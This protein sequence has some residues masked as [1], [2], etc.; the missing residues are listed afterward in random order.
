MAKKK[1]SK[2]KATAKKSTVEAVSLNPKQQFLVRI[3]KFRDDQAAAF[4]AR[5]PR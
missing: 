1:V 3:K 5:F 2:K 4:K